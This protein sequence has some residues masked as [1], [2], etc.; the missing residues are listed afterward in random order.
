MRSTTLTTSLDRR[1]R[2]GDVEPTHLSQGGD[3]EEML[4][5]SQMAYLFSENWP[6]SLTRAMCPR[7]C[8]YLSFFL[9]LAAWLTGG[10]AGSP[11]CCCGAVGHTSIPLSQEHSFL[12]MM[13][14]WLHCL[15]TSLFF[16]GKLVLEVLMSHLDDTISDNHTVLTHGLLRSVTVHIP[17]MGEETICPC[18][19]ARDH[20]RDWSALWDALSELRRMVWGTNDLG[21]DALGN[22]TVRDP[23]SPS[24]SLL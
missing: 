10:H 22:S 7:L 9:S 8:H 24:Y 14:Y 19:S 16:Q 6:E 2:K 1:Q 11:T 17:T 23:S 12:P 20:L 15:F 18:F 21:K 4:L 13:P 3:A 5:P